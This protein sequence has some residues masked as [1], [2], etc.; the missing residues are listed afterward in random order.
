[1]SR[2]N[3]S[4]IGASLC[5][6]REGNVLYSFGGI[7]LID[8]KWEYLDTI[9]RLIKGNACWEVLNVRLLTAIA[10]QGTL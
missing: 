7:R 3:E 4:K 8:N 1:M 2:L 5:L 9:E 10:F 6:I